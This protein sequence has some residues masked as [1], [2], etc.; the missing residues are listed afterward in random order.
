MEGRYPLGILIQLIDCTDPSQEN[1]FNRW[2]YRVFIPKCE[3]LGFIQNTRRYENFL[4]KEPTFRGRPKYL[5]IAEV[6]RT[7][8]KQALKEYHDF[9]AKLKAGGQD[10]KA[11]AVMLDT[12]YEQFGPELGSERTGR[13]VKVLYCGLLGCTDLT[14]EEEFNKWYADKHGPETLEAWAD[15]QY[16]YKAVDLNDPVPH[17]PTPY[18]TLYETGMEYSV[19]QDALTA[20][21]KQSASDPLWVNL[22]AVY[23]AA[24]FRPIQLK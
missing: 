21:R 20:F 8:L 22:L 14:R 5:T 1:E 15:T 3:A 23:F 24:L 6:Y 18:V 12:M 4:G 7:D 10:F 9:D 13:P 11:M 17:Q 16:R 19:L 2:Y